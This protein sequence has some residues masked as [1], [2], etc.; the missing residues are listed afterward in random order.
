M[1]YAG[2]MIE[3]RFPVDNPNRLFLFDKGCLVKELKPVNLIVNANP[4]HIS[5]S[6]SALLQK[7]KEKEKEKS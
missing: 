7:E 1:K 3:L 5:T 6:Y 4:P 2:D